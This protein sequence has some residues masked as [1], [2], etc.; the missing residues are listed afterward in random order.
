MASENPNSKA[1][2]RTLGVE[3]FIQDNCSLFLLGDGIRIVSSP[4][5]HNWTESAEEVSTSIVISPLLVFT[6]A[7]SLLASSEVIFRCFRLRSG[8]L[9]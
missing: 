9:R 2:Q 6:K 1:S 7:P 4:D 3:P 8:S 5:N